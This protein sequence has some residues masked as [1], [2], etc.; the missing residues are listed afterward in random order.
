[1]PV[2]FKWPWMGIAIPCVLISF[3]GYLSHYY[4]LR[5]HLSLIKQCYF[6]FS[7][8][9]I[10]VSYYMAIIINP[11]KPGKNFKPLPHE[12]RNFCKKCN[13]YKPERSHHCKT[14]NQCVLMMDHHCPWTMNCIGFNN[15]PHFMRF[16]LWIMATTGFL[17]FYQIKRIIYMWNNRNLPSYLF[18]RS[19][20]I[21]LFVCTPLNLF[22]LL[23]ITLLFCRC[24]FNQIINGKT[25]IEDW[26]MDRLENRFYL[27]KLLPQL[28]LNLWELYPEL[29]SA[30]HDEEAERLIEK[31]GIRYDSIVNFPYDLGI[32]KNITALVGQPL[33]WLWP[34]GGPSGNGMNFEKN[35]IALF[36][37]DSSLP[38]FTLAL[39]WPPD[40]GRHN[41][42]KTLNTDSNVEFIT[43]DGEQ[44]VRNRT[45]AKNPILSR[46]EWFNEWGENLE[47]FGVDVEMEN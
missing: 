10:W 7:L 41:N 39:P 8:T 6:E 27:K 15:F 23:T 11:G 32:F 44:V 46:E 33:Y 3:I 38:V 40:K 17:L 18:E 45:H 19:E 24:L 29:K 14:C 5:Q 30:K 31:K 43:T 12:W 36:D 1:M 2:K 28:I 35:E 37:P 22:I 21:A 34:F 13:N 16:L 4:I 20:V 25:Q 47:D 26:E 9:M 42:S